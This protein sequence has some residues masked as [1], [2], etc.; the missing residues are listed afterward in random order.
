[1]EMA[2]DQ[3]AHRVRAGGAVAGGGI[4][5][6]A[7]AL[8]A[9][10]PA[11]QDAAQAILNSLGAV[12]GAADAD[13][14]QQHEESAAPVVL[15]ARRLGQ[16][17]GKDLHATRHIVDPFAPDLG[18]ALPAG[19]GANDRLDI[20]RGALHEPVTAAADVGHAGVYELVYQHPVVEQPTAVDVG[21]DFDH[22]R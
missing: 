3:R 16:P 2:L 4:L 19:A 22:H 1:V 11:P 14:G 9:V 12:A 21:A 20:G 8:R 17:A 18:L 15:L 13:I 6:D 10:Q 5:R 7:N